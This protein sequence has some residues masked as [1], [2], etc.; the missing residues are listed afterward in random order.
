M[1]LAITFLM[2]FLVGPLVFWVLARHRPSRHRIAALM[3]VAA[4]LMA[5][6]FALGRW[7][8]PALAPSPYPGLAA[9]VA[10]WFAWIVMLAYCTL[11]AQYRLK[12]ATARKFIIAIGAM[13][14]TLPWFG[15]YTA[16]MMAEE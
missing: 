9:V 3:G 15:L 2:V 10:S 14:T 12:S 13:A 7:A 6:A 5:A 8:V 16:Q 4:C 1:K 11:A